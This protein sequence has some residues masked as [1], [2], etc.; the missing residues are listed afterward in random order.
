MLSSTSPL[1]SKTQVRIDITRTKYRDILR[2]EFIDRSDPSQEKIS[3]GEAFDRISS[4]VESIQY[5]GRK[6]VFDHRSLANFNSAPDILENRPVVCNPNHYLYFDRIYRLQVR[7][8][9]FSY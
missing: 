3:A 6:Y 2:T 4:A 1:P 9:P 8:E 7:F 5:K